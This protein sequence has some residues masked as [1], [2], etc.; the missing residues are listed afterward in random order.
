MYFIDCDVIAIDSIW[1]TFVSVPTRPWV[2]A[3][4]DPTAKE[5]GQ[6]RQALPQE[7]VPSPTLIAVGGLCNHSGQN[8]VGVLKAGAL[9]ESVLAI[10]TVSSAP[11]AASVFA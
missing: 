4:G 6:I 8:L 7:E 9:K 5:L 1:F 11:N 2:Q 10:I 3:C